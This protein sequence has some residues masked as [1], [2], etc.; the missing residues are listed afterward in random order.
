MA[1]ALVHV[2]FDENDNRG[3]DDLLEVIYSYSH[4]VTSE[5]LMVLKS[6]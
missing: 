5:E 1:E 4:F 3:L 6:S 2:L